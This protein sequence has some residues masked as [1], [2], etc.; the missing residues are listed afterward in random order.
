MPR[1]QFVQVIMCINHALIINTTSL[2]VRQA[3]LAGKKLGHHCYPQGE[4]EEDV[5]DSNT[6]IV[7]QLISLAPNLVH[8]KADGENDGGQAEQNH[9]Q[10]AKPASELDDPALPVGEGKENDGDIDAENTENYAD[11]GQEPLPSHRVR[12]EA[13]GGTPVDGE[14]GFE[15][16]DVGVAA[17]LR[18]DPVRHGQTCDGKDVCCQ[19]QRSGNHA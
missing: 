8:V 11:E 10:K 3:D 17:N 5:G 7:G 1:L 4:H 15:Q 12:N 19:E 2:E 13:D 9:G 18:D 14:T 16:A 6:E